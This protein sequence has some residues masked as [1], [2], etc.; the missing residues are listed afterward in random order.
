MEAKN[1]TAASQE[2]RDLL[3]EELQSP[4]F[5]KN[6]IADTLRLRIA[7]LIR[8]TREAQGLKQEQLGALMGKDQ[9]HV[10]RMEN[11]NY[12]KHSLASLLEVVNA[13][14]VALFVDV[15]PIS[16]F[17]TATQD[18]SPER[19]VAQSFN[20]DKEREQ[21]EKWR[22]GIKSLP[23]PTLPELASLQGKTSPQLIPKNPLE[24]NQCPSQPNRNDQPNLRQK[25][26]SKISDQKNS[27]PS[28]RIPS[29]LATHWTG[30]ELACRGMK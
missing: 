17:L 6:L 18:T 12:G 14:N 2:Y 26:D 27:Y 11:P 8:N 22:T 21:M 19:L 28:T 29:W 20:S 15:L 23:N 5:R 1:T 9:S 25:E 24:E 4:S 16:K 10:S 30:S 3:F 7:A 13:L